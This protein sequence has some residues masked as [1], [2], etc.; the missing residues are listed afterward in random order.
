MNRV[1]GGVLLGVA[2]LVGGVGVV[3]EDRPSLNVRTA[4]GPAVTE[5]AGP[6]SWPTLV[7]E[8][9]FPD[10][11]A[12]VYATYRSFGAVEQVRES[13]IVVLVVVDKPGVRL[14][15][16][17][18]PASGNPNTDRL[19]RTEWVTEYVVRIERVVKGPATRGQRVRVL[20]PEDTSTGL[21]RTGATYVLPLDRTL[22]DV[23]SQWFGTYASTGLPQGYGLESNGRMSVVAPP[24]L[25]DAS[26]VDALKRVFPSGSVD[27]VIEVLGRGR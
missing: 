14:A 6:Q 8:Q 15:L 2:T 3:I 21:L 24:E 5:A 19:D 20:I 22:A 9:R 25:T 26:A 17:V 13:D 1:V 16:E 4:T 12:T 27:D 7:D 10:G 23:G 18:P 11:G